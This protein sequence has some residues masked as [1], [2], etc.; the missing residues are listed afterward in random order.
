[1]DLLPPVRVL[2]VPSAR[3]MVAPSGR[4]SAWVL[5]SLTVRVRPV[6]ARVLVLCV[7]DQPS[8]EVSSVMAVRSMGV[9]T[10][11]VS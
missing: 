10:G 11:G 2:A 3:S 4:I 9:V 7:H 8:P 5:S 6:R 1:M